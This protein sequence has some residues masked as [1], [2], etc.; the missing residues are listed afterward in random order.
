MQARR[1]CPRER[2]AWLTE[3]SILSRLRYDNYL[4]H[5]RHPVQASK[6]R[7]ALGRRLPEG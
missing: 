1:E 6:A 5:P 2:N 3:E 4:R 7:E